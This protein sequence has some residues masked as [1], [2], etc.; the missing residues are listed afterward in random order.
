MLKWHHLSWTYIFLFFQPLL[1][2]LHSLLLFFFALLFKLC[3]ETSQT[4]K[5]LEITIAIVL[6]IYLVKKTKLV[7]PKMCQISL[8]DFTY[9]NFDLRCSSFAFNFSAFSFSSFSFF[10]RFS[11]SSFSFFSRFSLSRSSFS[12]RA[13][14]FFFSFAALASSF[15]RCFSCC[16]RSRSSCSCKL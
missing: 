1:F 8:N 12:L 16:S 11:R 2:F 3:P 5:Y 7:K 14:S 4:A 10:S 15:C 6:H 9:S 13:S